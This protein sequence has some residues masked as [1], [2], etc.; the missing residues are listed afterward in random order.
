MGCNINMHFICWSTGS[1]RVDGDEDEEDVDD[2][3]NEFNYRQG[4]GKTLNQQWQP[5]DA[6]LSSSSRHDAHR[7]PRLTSGQQVL[8][9]L[10]SCQCI[11]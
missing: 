10:L 2:I 1:P 7:I 3:D 11:F 6:D 5:G 8:T 9:K 4:A